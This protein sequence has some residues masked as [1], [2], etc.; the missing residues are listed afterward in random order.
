MN[1]VLVIDDEAGIR[2][3]LVRALPVRGYTAESASNAEDALE[4]IAHHKFELIV[5]D[6][7]M[8]G[9]G[10][11]DLLKDIKRLRPYADVIMAT[12]YGALDTAIESMRRGAYDYITKPYTLDQLCPILEAALVIQRSRKAAARLQRDLSY[13]RW[14]A[15]LPVGFLILWGIT[16][17]W[18][19]VEPEELLILRPTPSHAQKIIAETVT[20]KSFPPL[21][22]RPE[23]VPKNMAIIRCYYK[24]P[25]ISSGGTLDFDINGSGFSK[26]FHRTLYVKSGAPDVVTQDLQW[27]TANQIHG[28]MTAT[29]AAKTQYLRPIVFIRDHAVFQADS[30]FAVIRS[31]DVL[32]I[33]LIDANDTGSAGKYRLYANLDPAMEKRLR[34]IP[35]TP[36]LVLSAPRRVLPYVWEGTVHLKKPIPGV[37]GVKVYIGDQDVYENNEWIHTVKPNIGN[38]G[39]A[40][41]LSVAEPHRRP[42]DIVTLYLLGSGFDP[43]DIAMFTAHMNE[44]DMGDAVF[45]YDSPGRLSFT[46]HIPSRTPEGAY[47]VTVYKNKQSFHEQS[48]LFTVVPMNWLEQIVITPSLS[49]GHKSELRLKGR[50]FTPSGVQALAITAADEPGLHISALHQVD[51]DT[52]TADIHAAPNVTPGEYLLQINFHGL[53][54]KAAKEHFIVKVE[55]DGTIH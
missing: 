22:L 21:I 35:N 7:R 8:P 2:D 24:Y 16:R 38:R 6:I 46:F 51:A 55:P 1:H 47:G 52:L 36:E 42:G 44:W 43:K 5:C 3:W 26:T 54:I 4:K 48:H 31:G 15:L 41:K 19:R 13:L 50:D 27:V 34:I 29:A 28:Q 23:L 49:P 20:P 53:P 30:P 12:G 39:F 45:K 32:D 25:I 14:L 9:Q 11:V 33:L 10:G 37:Y 18:K 17:V 40:R